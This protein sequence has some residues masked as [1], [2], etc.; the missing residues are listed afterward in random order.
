MGTIPDWI[1]MLCIHSTSD[2]ANTAFARLFAES[3]MYHACLARKSLSLRCHP[4]DLHA[5]S[6][7][8]LACRFKILAC[9]IP[10]ESLIAVLAIKRLGW[11]AGMEW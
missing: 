7:T 9:W 5:P 6:H 1:T 3:S 2:S 10:L 4:M 11:I 8:A